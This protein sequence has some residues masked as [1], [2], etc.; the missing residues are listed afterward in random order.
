MVRP[1][2]DSSEREHQSRRAWPL[3]CRSKFLR[4][5]RGTSILKWRRCLPSWLGADDGVKP[6]LKIRKRHSKWEFERL[7]TLSRLFHLVQFVK[8]CQFFSG[9]EF[10]KT[11]WKFRKRK[12]KSLSCVH[13]LQKTWNQAFLRRRSAVTKER[14]P[15]KCTKK[16]DARAK[17]FFFA[18]LY[19]V[20]FCDS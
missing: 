12:V 16:G 20:P 11:I 15:K 6:T 14:N 10:W 3:A 13:V 18:N 8:C 1:L 17:W 9:V 7:Q 5:G 4:W 2:S 19:P